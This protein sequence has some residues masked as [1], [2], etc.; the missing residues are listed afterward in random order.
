[1]VVGWFFAKKSV[2]S[3]TH[4]WIWPAEMVF[5]CCSKSDDWSK[6]NW[7]GSSLDFFS[8][9]KAV[10]SPTRVAESVLSDVLLEIIL[11]TCIELA[12]V[13]AWHICARRICN[14]HALSR[15]V[16]QTIANLVAGKFRVARRVVVVGWRWGWVDLS[17]QPTLDPKYPWYRTTRWRKF[18]R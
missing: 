16:A 2:D 15:L 10:T 14:R 4:V 13:H 11:P 3:K 12:K 7:I 9:T 1:M 5:V 17:W 8:P 6:R 18:Q